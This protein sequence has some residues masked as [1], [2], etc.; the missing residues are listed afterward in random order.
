[1]IVSVAAVFVGRFFR[2]AFVWAVA[3]L[4]A[5]LFTSVFLPA[6]ETGSQ[7]VDISV[8]IAAFATSMLAFA[9]A[10]VGTVWALARR[11]PPASFERQVALGVASVYVTLAVIGVLALLTILIVRFVAR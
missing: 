8:I 3:L 4:P 10:P 2:P 6:F 9:L 7:E 5:A 1:M 11:T